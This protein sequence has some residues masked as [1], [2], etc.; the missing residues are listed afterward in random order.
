MACS[1]PPEVYEMEMMIFGAVSLTCSAQ[2]AKN[3]NAQRFADTMP[4]AV[5]AILK[6]LCMGDYLDSADAELESIRR[7]REVIHLH[8]QGGFEM[9]N[10]ISS[11]RR[12]LQAIPEHLRA[13]GD[14]DLKSGIA[15]PIEQTLGVRCNPN[16]DCFVF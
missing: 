9:R 11:S 13:R 16:D 5:D 4:E 2:F 10:W 6:K 8:E 14:I 12:V 1:S 7:V 3:V 15:L